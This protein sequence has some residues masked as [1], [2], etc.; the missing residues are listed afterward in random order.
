[1]KINEE[2]ALALAVF[3]IVCGLG[4]CTYIKSKEHVEI[5]KIECECCKIKND[6][7]N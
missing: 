6:E 7:I 2:L 5:K 4:T 1:M 3:F